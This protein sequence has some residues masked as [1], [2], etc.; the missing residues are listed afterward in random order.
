MESG[1]LYSKVD[2]SIERKKERLKRDLEGLSEIEYRE[3]FNI[4]QA[5]TTPYSENKNGIFVNLRHLDEETIDKIYEFLEFSKSNKRYLRE[6][7]EKQNL[8]KQSIESTIHQSIILSK[9]NIANQVV[10]GNNFEINT[11]KKT[12]VDNFTFQKF[13]DKLTITNM[14]MFPEND[15]IVYPMIKQ[16]KWNVQG[17]KLRLLKKCKEINKYNYDRFLNPYLNNNEE[18]MSAISKPSSI[19]F[20][21]QEDDIL[22]ED[23]EDFEELTEDED[24]EFEDESDDDTET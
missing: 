12:T 24:E 5:H 19:S 20:K 23:E 2:S 14:K 21:N 1:G 8:E 6:I 17:V 11:S 7:E 15:K 10:S 3:V 22:D 18:S 13:I 4:I 16:H 9:D